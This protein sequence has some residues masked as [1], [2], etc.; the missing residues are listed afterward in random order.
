MKW[1]D[2]QSLSAQMM[3]QLW[4]VGQHQQPV[5]RMVTL[6]AAALPGVAR[7]DLLNLSVGQRDSYLLMLRECSF[8]SRFAGYAECPG[9]QE[10][11]ECSFAMGDIWVGAAP[12]EGIGQIRLVQVG[13]YELKV[14]LP[15]QADVLAIAVLQS[16]AAARTR[17]L[18][19]CVLQAVHGGETVGVL[20]LPDEIVS[21]VGERIVQEDA[22]AEVQLALGCPACEQSWSVHFDIATFL[23][24][25]IATQAKRL[26]R[27]VHTL[28]LAYGWSEAD[29]LAMSAIRRQCYLEMVS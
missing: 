9:C 19:C 21:A 4:E 13:D 26:L 15:T 16:V 10:R 11:I 2:M 8:G 18:Q 12:L 24:A 25:E 1:L 23:W 17:L 5:E 6:L 20:D 7:A 14:R 28:A 29:I 22:Q 27:E 3:L